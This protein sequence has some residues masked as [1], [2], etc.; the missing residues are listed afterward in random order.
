MWGTIKGGFAVKKYY[1]LVFVIIVVGSIF[2]SSFGAKLE[3][4]SPIIQGMAMLAFIIP[5][6]VLLYLIGMDK[7]IKNG[8]RIAAKIG[9]AFLI[10]CYIGGLVAELI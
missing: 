1:L 4:L 2:S 9:I 3:S 5:A 7:K 6:C 8:F 10:F